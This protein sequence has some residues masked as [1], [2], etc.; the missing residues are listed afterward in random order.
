[1]SG[2]QKMYFK[3]NA[4]KSRIIRLVLEQCE[5]CRETLLFD[6]GCGQAKY[7]PKVLDDHPG[8]SLVYYDPARK[9]MEQA[10]ANLAGKQARA[11]AD[12]LAES[13]LNV[14]FV[15]SFSVF[16]HVWDRQGYLRTAFRHLKPGGVLFLNYD[17][18]HFRNNISLNRPWRSVSQIKEFLFNLTARPL[19]RLG[20]LSHYQRRVKRDTAEAMVTEAGF[21]V[22]EVF[23]SNLP[24]LKGLYGELEEF[25]W[26]EEIRREY[27]Q[28]WQELE[29]FLNSRLLR[30][31]EVERLG[32]RANL[33]PHTL[34][35]TLVLRKP[36][37]EVD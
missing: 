9:S 13:S 4:A 1:M 37:G 16:E 21:A 26:S 24:S 25:G 17:D 23:Y 34:S 28:K 10:K 14:D 5:D 12:P 3:G 6:Y 36:E 27:A 8:L 35:R 18:G 11:L 32:D 19:A 20:I 2:S 31:E 15:I 30:D 7:W 29:E 22:E 33:W